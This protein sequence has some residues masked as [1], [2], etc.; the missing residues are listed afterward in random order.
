MNFPIKCEKIKRFFSKEVI[1]LG[2]RAGGC[3][4][5]DG[6]H[7]G[8]VVDAKGDRHLHFTSL[9]VFAGMRDQSDNQISHLEKW[10][11]V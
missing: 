5:S 9:S 3:L 4:F 11:S 7:R 10:N 2:L 8:E 1:N 6:Q